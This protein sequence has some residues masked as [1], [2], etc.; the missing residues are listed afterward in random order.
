M[1]DKELRGLHKATVTKDMVDYNGH[2]NVAYYVQV[3]DGSTD[4]FMDVIGLTA[5]RRQRGGNTL[6]TVEGHITYQKE[7]HLGDE[8]TCDVRLLG[9]DEKRLRFISTMLKEPEGFVAATM[10]WLHI[11]VDLPTRKVVPMPDDVLEELTVIMAQHEQLEWPAEAGRAIERPT[12][13]AVKQP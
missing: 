2:L 8:L 4:A 11:H 3:F 10:E 1:A 9:F 7:V 12:G 13:R 5:E 6:F